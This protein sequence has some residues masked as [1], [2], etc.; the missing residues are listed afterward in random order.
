MKDLYGNYNENT[1]AYDGNYNEDVPVNIGNPSWVEIGDSETSPIYTA[2]RDGIVDFVAPTVKY[3]YCEVVR[4]TQ[5]ET[6]Y[7]EFKFILEEKYPLAVFGSGSDE[8]DYKNS[9][10]VK[11]IIDGEDVTDELNV[12][13]SSE[14]EADGQLHYTALV[15]NFNTAYDG[16][17]NGYSGPVTF[18]VKGNLTDTSGNKN[19]SQVVT[20]QVEG[21]DDA[22][23]DIVSPEFRKLE[24]ESYEEV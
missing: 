5:F 23:V 24:R 13:F 9:E 12:E 1:K 18:E 20:V 10:Y 11:I 3:E 22:I 7:L 4:P 14:M 17:Y 2:Y 15:T 8:E 21:R 6:G 16:R 19:I